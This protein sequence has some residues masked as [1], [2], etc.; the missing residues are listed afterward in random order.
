MRLLPRLVP[1][2]IL[3]AGIVSF[4]AA[5]TFKASPDS[6]LQAMLDRARDGDVVELEPG[7]HKGAI[8]IERRLCHSSRERFRV[9][10][11][12]RP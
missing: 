7:E 1:A 9:M 4:A 10:R 11:N 2:A 5:E 8:R 12:Q 6:P 3:A